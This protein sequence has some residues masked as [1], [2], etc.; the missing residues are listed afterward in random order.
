MWCHAQHIQL[1][2]G[3]SEEGH[4]RW[5]CLSSQVTPM[6]DGAPLSW[7]CLNICL[8]MGSREWKPCFQH[9]S[10]AYL[11]CLYLDPWVFSL[12]P[13]NSLSH[14]NWGVWSSDCMMLS[15]Q[16]GLNHNTPTSFL[17]LKSSCTN[18][19]VIAECTINRDWHI[20]CIRLWGFLIA[21]LT[22]K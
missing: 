4:L 2:E 13:S 11:K 10:S 20:L 12:F 3:G 19:S 9:T 6:S 22:V 5:W 15:Y 7:R 18:G 14:P 16:L 21:D 8:L 1:E 17:I